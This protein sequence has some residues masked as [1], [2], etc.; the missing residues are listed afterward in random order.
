[1]RIYAIIP[2]RAGSKGIPR[3]NVNL[4]KGKPLIAYSLQLCKKSSL[5]Q[6]TIVSTD[7]KEYAKIANE[8]G[9]ETPFLRPVEISKDNSTDYEFVV[10]ALEWFGKNEGKIPE[11]L[12]HLRPTTPLRRIEIVDAAIKKLIKQ[13][14]ATAL[15]SV[16][17]MPE[18]A[19]KCFEIDDG[20]L[21]TIGNTGTFNLDDANN[22]RQSFPKTYHANGYV[23]VIKTEF[24][25]NNNRLHGSKVIPFITPRTNEV[26]CPDD[27]DQLEFDIYKDDT[28]FKS[29]FGE[30]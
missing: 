24:I 15:R 5:I 23:D 22:A 7:S 4:L 14:D 17:E 27:L 18:S 1:M 29:L 25:I 11:Y 16:H 10:H 26:D 2:A 6:R 30:D 9:G 3:K 28:I 19:Y 12:V 20:Y 8:Y 21:K 13:N